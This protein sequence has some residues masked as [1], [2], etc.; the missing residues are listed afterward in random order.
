MTRPKFPHFILLPLPIFLNPRIVKRISK[1]LAVIL[2]GLLV[3]GLC[4]LWFLNRWLHSPELHTQIEQEL[5]KALR[6]EVKLQSVDI[7]LFGQTKVI[8]I[9]IPQ[10]NEDFFAASGFTAKHQ[11]TSLLTGKLVLD[12]ILVDAPTFIIR[13]DED[14]EWLIPRKEETKKI[15]LPA[16]KVKETTKTDESRKR[17]D[18]RVE[19]RRVRLVNGSTRVFNV[20]GDESMTFT[21][22]NIVVGKLTPDDIEGS[23]VAEKANFTEWG[24]LEKFTAGFSRTEEKGIII[25]KFSALVGG[26]KINGGFS[27]KADDDELWSVKLELENV[28]TT[29]ALAAEVLSNMNVSGVISG[30]L[31]LRGA[32]SDE[33]LIKGKSNLILKNVHFREMDTIR[34]IGALLGIS[35]AANF[36]ITEAKLDTAIGSER[37]FI[38]EFSITASSLMIQSKGTARFDSKL[39]LDALLLVKDDVL[40]QRQSIEAQFSPPDENGLRSV[41]FE[42]RGNWKKPKYKESLMEKITGTKDRKMQ[43]I[44]LGEA[45]LFGPNGINMENKQP[46]EEPS[47]KPEETEP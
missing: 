17:W 24:V 47:S 28:D 35:D 6:M 2:L 18:S 32:G 31:E 29:Q 10:H 7:N 9:R 46:E 42:I 12:E 25:P 14:G 8:G 23:L 4:G 1:I 5:G 22:I 3:V 45:I 30:Y 39:K 20:E 38:N 41:P 13:E 21:G 43:K 36:A 11:I 40:K 27:K 26:G 44:I 16:D 37:F 15:K 34:E 19:I 33:K